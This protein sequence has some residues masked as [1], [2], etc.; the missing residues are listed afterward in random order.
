MAHKYIVKSNQIISE[1]AGCKEQLMDAFEQIAIN[2]DRALYYGEGNMPKKWVSELA[3]HN[4]KLPTT[5]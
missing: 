2:L 5:L 4:P 1:M 3:E